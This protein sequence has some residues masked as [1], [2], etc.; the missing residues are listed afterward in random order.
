MNYKNQLKNIWNAVYNPS[1]D[2]HDTI[3]KFFHPEYEQCINGVIM[4]L[5]EY[6]AHVIEQKKNMTI[7]SIDYLHTL[8][9]GNELF[10]IYYPHGKNAN[11]SPI[12][13]EVIAYFRF[14]DQQIIR[15][16]GQVRL[17]Q[18]DLKDVDMH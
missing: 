4:R 5:P 1:Q 8:E 14:E 16:H 6:I 7:D 10:T 17:I 11:D 18:G 2:T 13:A 15:I 12:K 9:K 3:L